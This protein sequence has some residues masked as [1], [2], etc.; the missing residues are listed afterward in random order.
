[1]LAALG[2]EALLS[3][4]GV[5]L[6]S[7]PLVFE[8]RT[9]IVCLVVGVG[10][11]LV[12]AISPARR[13]VR[14]APVAAVSEQ[15]SEAE[16]PFRRRFTWGIG[17]TLVG[18]IALAIGLTAPAIALVGLGAV[19]IF[20]GVARLAPGRGAADVERHR[21]AAGRPARDVG[22]AGPGE[23]H[24]QP[25]PHGADGVGPHGRPGACLGDR[26][27]RGLVVALGD[28]QCRQCDQRRPHCLDGNNTQGGFSDAVGPTAAAVDGVTASITVYQDQFEVQ[29]GLQSLTAISTRDLADTVILNM[30]EGSSSTLAD[31]DLL[32]DTNTANSKHLSVGDVVPVRFAKTGRTTMRIGGVFKANQLIGKYLV[33]DGFF[34]RAL[35]ERVC[36]S[37]SC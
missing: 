29:G 13:A 20:I 25:A 23:L 10:V 15:Q 9:V 27:L 4:F 1:M 6:P 11:T 33:G 30:T 36:R 35:L 14:I 18:V 19:F 8:A 21:P 16:I 22:P 12:S 28:E 5:T 7:G 32:I 2:L 26:R 37:R 34:L 3:G 31:G 24:A 17:I